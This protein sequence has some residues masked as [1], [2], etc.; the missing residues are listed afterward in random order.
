MKKRIILLLTFIV[1][2]I[3]CTD[4]AKAANVQELTCVYDKTKSQPGIKFTIDKSG[5]GNLYISPNNVSSLSA[6]TN[7]IH[8]ITN[9]RLYVDGTAKSY[10]SCPVCIHYNSKSGQIEGPDDEGVCKTP[11]NEVAGT[12]NTGLSN[13][14]VDDTHAYEIY[15]ANPKLVSSE[16]PN[17][18]IN[19]KPQSDDDVLNG[20]WIKKCVYKK[21]NNRIEIY[22]NRN[23][24]VL[25]DNNISILYGNKTETIIY[26][27]T[28][29]FTIN[30]DHTLEQLVKK[31]NENLNEDQCYAHV[32]KS[33]KCTNPNERN[34]KNKKYET[35]YYKDSKT[36][37]SNQ[38][39]YVRDDAESKSKTKP[40]KEEITT[41]EALIGKSTIELINTIMKYIRI[42]VPLLLIGFGVSDFAIAVFS[43]KEEDTKKSREKFI[44]RIIAA[45]LVFLSPIFINLLLS[46]A[47]EVWTWITPETCIK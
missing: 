19:E 25:Y 30:N 21:D 10:T 15:G 43:S 4:I 14:T 32:Y 17:L 13:S 8:Q 26:I 7:W 20:T 16:F 46:L 12:L 35:S 11:E 3:M 28:K 9:D 1:S 37:N 41:C 5:N 2:F 45:V 24:F 33:T 39:E 29:K 27:E 42:A 34:K 36:T 38:E 40:V 44:K 47:N 18:V 6:E 31:Y 22:F 23:E